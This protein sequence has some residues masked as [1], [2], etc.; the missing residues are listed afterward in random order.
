[1]EARQDRN[2]EYY[3]PHLYPW[4]TKLWREIKYIGGDVKDINAEIESGEM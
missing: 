3:F 2:R 4:Y 1:M